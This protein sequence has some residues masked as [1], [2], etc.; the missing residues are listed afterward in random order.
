MSSRLSIAICTKDHPVEL[1]RC[2]RSLVPI[3]K[4]AL[5]IIVVDNNSRDEQTGR[6]AESFGVKCVKET[7]PG[8]AAAR[9]RAIS[10][11]SG[12]LLAFTDDDCEAT[13][14]WISAV[15]EG[16][17]DPQV[18]CV[19]GPA[20]SPPGSNW[21]QR[22]FESHSR[23]FFGDQPLVITP[24]AVRRKYWGS[25]G[26]GANMAF[27]RELLIALR[28]FPEIFR[29][30]GDDNYIFFK[31]LQA[32]FKNKYMP[33]AIV[34]QH[35]RQRFSEHLLRFFQY[36]LADM[37]FIWQVSSDLRSPGLFLWNVAYLV[38]SM[39]HHA[40]RS[41]LKGSVAHVLFDISQGAGIVA[42]FFMPWG[43]RSLWKAW[44]T[45]QRSAG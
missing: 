41:L 30:S 35:H 20:I 44:W 43:W 15:V 29:D 23:V 38:L 37:R 7:S 14:G 26:V 11:V 33:A 31:V 27:R 6:V 32:G 16:F 40:L 22:Q 10:A 36:G 39:F 45:P 13:P 9:N 8:L 21:A 24:E 4:Q 1:A 19:T 5:E 42:G 28:G 2:L 18:G 3:R 12:D 34:Y 17:A 25:V